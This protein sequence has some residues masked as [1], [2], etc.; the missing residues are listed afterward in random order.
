[1]RGPDLI[2][3]ISATASH[4]RCEY[5][6]SCLYCIPRL[7]IRRDMSCNIHQGRSLCSGPEVSAELRLT[8]EGEIVYEQ[9]P[10]SPGAGTV[11]DHLSWKNSFPIMPSRLLISYSGASTQSLAATAQYHH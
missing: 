11:C 1:M 4:K 8:C 5:P 3:C 6:L 9:T 2:G 10:T 7:S